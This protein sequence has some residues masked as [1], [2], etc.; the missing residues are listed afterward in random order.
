MKLAIMQPYFF[1]YI[2]YFQLI[3][4]VDKFIIY[5]DVNYIKQ[6]WINRNQILVAGQ[7]HLFVVP[8]KRASSFKLIK[9]IELEEKTYQQWRSKFT[10]TLE[11]NYRKA[12]YYTEVSHL[13]DSV[14]RDFTLHISTLA[15]KSLQ[16]VS[17]YLG[18][19]TQFVPSSSVYNT[20][21]LEPTEKLISMYQA[22][23]ASLYINPIGG[24]DLF[25][26]EELQQKGIEIFF[27]KSKPICYQQFAQDFVPWLSIIDVLMFNSRDVVNEF[28]T[29]Y[30]LI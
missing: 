19:Q 10:K 15:L 22:E 21:H 18:I 3:G 5:D 13:I 30:E 7:S 29:A 24:V 16:A 20:A 12:P 8:L 9:E 2:G 28:L 14:I 26:R 6:G 17:Q 11:V 4:A 25:R 1:P 23:S 27:L